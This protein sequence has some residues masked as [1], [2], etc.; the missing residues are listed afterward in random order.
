MRSLRAW[1]LFLLVVAGCGSA[2]A[3]TTMPASTTGLV[4]TVTYRDDL[5]DQVHI[6]GT[7]MVTAR[8]FGPYD[9]TPTQLPS[10]KTLGLVFDASD[11][12]GVMV[13]G[14]ADSAD[15]DGT[16][17]HDGFGG[18]GSTEPTHLAGCGMYTLVG[19]QVVD[20]ELTLDRL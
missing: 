2:P 6:N 7:T 16:G 19:G 5:V 15:R 14:T 12:G 3:P 20:G 17:T 10:G 11:A 9:V 18:H 4:L 13:C 8:K 1:S